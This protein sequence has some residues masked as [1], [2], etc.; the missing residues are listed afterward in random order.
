MFDVCSW[1]HSL[2][3]SKWLCRPFPLCV[4]PVRRTITCQTQAI[5]Q[6]TAYLRTD[7]PFGLICLTSGQRDMIL[8]WYFWN[9]LCGVSY[10]LTAFVLRSASMGHINTIGS[11]DRTGQR[12]KRGP[13]GVPIGDMACQSMATLSRLAPHGE[14]PPPYEWTLSMSMEEVVSVD[15]LW[16]QTFPNVFGYPHFKINRNLP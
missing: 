5:T 1:K 6:W 12:P 13:R 9:E 4:G 10:A 3:W 7:L 11:L 16:M 14:G 15:E 2:S 8:C